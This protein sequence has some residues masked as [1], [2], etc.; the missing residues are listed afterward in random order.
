MVKKLLFI[1]LV[2]AIPIA[3][4]A[5]AAIYHYSETYQSPH[6]FKSFPPIL[7]SLAALTAV[8]AILLAALLALVI[9]ENKKLKTKTKATENITQESRTQN[10]ELQNK[11]ELLSATREISLILNQDVDFET[12]LKKTL[13]VTAH[14]LN[15]LHAP[16]TTATQ[17]HTDEIMIFSVSAPGE[18]KNNT[19]FP[20]AQRK[21]DKT[22]FESD[23]RTVPY[24]SKNV[25]ESAEHNRILFLTEEDELDLTCPLVANREVI[26]VLKI[27]TVLEGSSQEKTKQIRL[28][29]SIFQEFNK[30]LALAIKTPDL[31]QR[32]ITDGLTNLFSKRHFLTQ[33]HTCFEI[34][35]RHNQPLSLIMLDLDHFKSINDTYGHLTGDVVLKEV[36]RLI[37]KSIRATSSAYRYG[38]EELAIILPNTPLAGATNLAERLRKKIAGQKFNAPAVN[39]TGHGNESTDDEQPKFIEVTASLGAAEYKKEMIDIK[40]LI[41]QADQALYQAKQTGRNKVCVY[42]K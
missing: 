25:K 11:I 27:K 9:W 3:T 6:F 5:L 15:S 42:A 29:Q 22:Y 39:G 8:Y 2:G 19:L 18:L 17:T 21:G 20:L 31:Y 13:E 24:D 37:E 32:T 40:E 34:A 36:A 26:G 16:H 10:Q 35:R 7:T 14:L 1:F 12:I 33:L 41:Q 38:G 30:I 4:L 23:F 28:L